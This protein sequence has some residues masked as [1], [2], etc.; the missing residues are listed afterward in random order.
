MASDAALP[1]SEIQEWS[2]RRILAQTVRWTMRKEEAGARAT[3]E[4]E[5]EEEGFLTKMVCGSLH[6]SQSVCRGVCS[7]P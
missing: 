3:A 6:G 1:M 7:L 4:E 5:E 2:K